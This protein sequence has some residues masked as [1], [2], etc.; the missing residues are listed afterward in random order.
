MTSWPVADPG[1]E[2]RSCPPSNLAIDFGP[3]SSK[4]EVNVKYWEKY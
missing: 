3:C 2:I 1:G 4:E